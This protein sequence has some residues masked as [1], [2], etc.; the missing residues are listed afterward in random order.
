MLGFAP[1]DVK[2]H[3]R[4]VIAESLRRPGRFRF[5][6]RD[7]VAAFNGFVAVSTMGTV[8]AYEPDV[9]LPVADGRGML[10]ISG[11]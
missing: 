2:G 1:L 7:G 4:R 10:R 9:G 11:N 8:Q 5:G 3:S 6:V